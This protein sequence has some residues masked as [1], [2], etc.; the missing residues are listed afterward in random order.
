M[1]VKKVKFEMKSNNEEKVFITHR[2]VEDCKLKVRTIFLNDDLKT[3]KII[4]DNNKGET[5]NYK[6]VKNLEYVH[7]QL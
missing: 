7:L 1:K 5:F 4:Y 6:D 2:N 3:I